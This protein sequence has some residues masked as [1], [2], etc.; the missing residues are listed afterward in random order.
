VVHDPFEGSEFI[1]L[2]FNPSA[3]GVAVLASARPGGMKHTTY[4][5]VN[6]DDAIRDA[7]EAAERAQSRGLPLRYAVVRIATEEV[8]PPAAG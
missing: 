7:R 4:S 1:V 5:D 2:E 8:F 3:A 6:R